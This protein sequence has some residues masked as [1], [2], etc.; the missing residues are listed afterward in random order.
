MTG[1]PA[2][3]VTACLVVVADSPS[4]GSLVREVLGTMLPGIESRSVDPGAT[5]LELN[6][7]DCIVIDAA[8]G[9]RSGASML[10]R[11][12]AG[13]YAGAAVVLVAG[14]DRDAEAE[15]T[16]LGARCV[17]SDVV[18]EQLAPAVVGALAAHRGDAATAP[19]RTAL[20]RAQRL[21][22]AGEIALRLQHSLNNPLAALLAES[23]LLEMEDLSPEHH[24][25]V[26]RIVEQL[27]RVIAI[28]RQLDGVAKPAG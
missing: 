7:T 25:A 14:A 27:R 20:D 12:R 18:A 13:G 11:I 3:L 22:A 19:A 17:G 8:V 1:E 4:T 6:R 15:A 24:E 2:A 10:R 26:E 9:G 16:A 21:I 5:A 28:V 23:Q